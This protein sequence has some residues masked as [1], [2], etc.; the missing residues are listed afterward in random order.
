LESRKKD[1]VRVGVQTV[2]FVAAPTAMAGGR[3]PVVARGDK[4]ATMGPT[5]SLFLVKF[6]L[7]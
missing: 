1:S 6:S 5:F 3:W 2:L 4:V 7:C